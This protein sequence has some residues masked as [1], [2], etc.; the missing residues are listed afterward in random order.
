M[1]YIVRKEVLTF[2]HSF[3]YRRPRYG[4]RAPME[5]FP[6][7]LYHQDWHYFVKEFRQLY[8]LIFERHNE[9]ASLRIGRPNLCHFYLYSYSKVISFLDLEHHALQS[10]IQGSKGPILFISNWL[11]LIS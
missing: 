7:R 4:Q 6:D 11:E 2:E 10:L 1:H 3:F 8:N 5:L 9:A